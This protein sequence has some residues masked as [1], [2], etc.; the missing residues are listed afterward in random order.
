MYILWK[1]NW[2]EKTA[3]T[4]FYISGYMIVCGFDARIFLEVKYLLCIFVYHVENVSYGLYLLDLRGI[5][6]WKVLEIYSM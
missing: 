6:T 4:P 5:E 2:I 1:K 3:K